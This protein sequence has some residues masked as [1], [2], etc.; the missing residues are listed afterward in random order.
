MEADGVGWWWNVP[1]SLLGWITLAGF[2]VFPS[3]F[4]SLQES[5]SIGESKGG[6]ALQDAIK[7]IP[8]FGVAIGLCAIGIG[9][10][11]AMWYCH[12][13]KKVWILSH[14]LV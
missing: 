4:T 11:F 1:T 9:G 12:Y 13:G 14:I 3:T 10:S 5:D 8:L 7:R 6:R 2:L